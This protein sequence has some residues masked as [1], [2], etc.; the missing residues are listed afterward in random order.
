MAR[1]MQPRAADHQNQEPSTEEGTV[2]KSMLAVP[3][4][5]G[6]ALYLPVADAHAQAPTP[7]VVTFDWVT[8]G[9]PGNACDP[10]GSGR[11]FG[12]VG[13]TYRIARHEVTNARYAAF[14]NAKAAS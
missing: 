10:L 6:G 4:L 2:S 12:A 9:D 5:L 3:A 11:C 8:V 14:L 7:P 1:G 13:Y